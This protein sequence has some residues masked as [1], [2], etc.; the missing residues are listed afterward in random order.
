[1]KGESDSMRFE[2]LAVLAFTVALVLSG[3]AGGVKEPNNAPSTS[4][5]FNST[6]ESRANGAG[7]DGSGGSGSGATG[8]TTTQ[9]NQP[10]VGS[11]AASITQGSTPVNATFDLKG[12]DPDGDAIDWD[13]DFDGDQ[14]TDKS[15]TT[16]PARVHFNYTAVGLYN[17]TFTIQDDKAASTSYH[18]LINATAAAAGQGPLFEASGSY[19]A[20]GVEN[21]CANSLLGTSFWWANGGVGNGVDQV[22]FDLPP[23]IVGQ[24]TATYETSGPAT[25]Y[26]VTYW[27]IADDNP[28]GTYVDETISSSSPVTGPVPEAN[29]V[30]ISSCGGAQVTVDFRID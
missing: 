13:I 1:V 16:L 12:T 2:T 7:Q 5:A 8:G 24:F 25:E 20:G 23:N 6:S 22:N 27:L 4:S 11:I 3:C 9:A 28:A 15:G 29:N 30:R 18:V 10:P 14:R 19:H 17:V 21:A 26:A